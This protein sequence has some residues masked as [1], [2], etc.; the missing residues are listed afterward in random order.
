[1]KSLFKQREIWLALAIVVLIGIIAIIVKA[2]LKAMQLRD[3][4]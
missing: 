1:M 3:R 2:P 4:A